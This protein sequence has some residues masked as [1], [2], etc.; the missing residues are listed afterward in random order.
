MT[1]VLDSE[2]YEW[3]L[4]AETATCED[5]GVTMEV[6]DVDDPDG[7]FSEPYFRRQPCQWSEDSHEA[8]C[9]GCYSK[10]VGEII[11]EDTA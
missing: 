1:V 9:E 7:G 3:G 2:M 8:L 11:A 10:A 5:C 4:T 6:P